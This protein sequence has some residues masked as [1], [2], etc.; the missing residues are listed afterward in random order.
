[1][2]PHPDPP[3]SD[4]ALRLALTEPRR[5]TEFTAWQAHIP[6][7]FVVVRLV[8]PRRLVELGTAGG[9]AY[10]AFCQSV[11]VNG[12]DTECAAVDTWTGDPHSGELH[13]ELFENLRSHHDPLYGHFSRLVRSTFDD[14]RP[15]FADQT[16]DLLHIDGYHTYDAV[17]HD[18]ESWLPKMS[19][20]GVVLLH[21]VAVRDGDF[22]VWRL[23]E[24]IK[25]QYPSFAFLHGHGLGIVIVG[26]SATNEIRRFVDHANARDSVASLFEALG[27]R[28]VARTRLN[29]LRLAV[30]E[31]RAR[32]AEL[33]QAH[34]ELGF[35]L[36]RSVAER[37]VAEERLADLERRSVAERG[38]AE[39]R[40]GDLE[41]RHLADRSLT[42]EQL[43]ALERQV[44]TERLER[45]TE[46]AARV[47]AERHLAELHATRTLRYTRAA[48][49]AYARLRRVRAPTKNPALDLA[50]GS[51]AAA[52]PAHESIPEASHA[53][54]V[55]AGHFYSA[56]PSLDD[57]DHRHKEIFDRDPQD[58]GGIDLRLS[59]QV[60]FLERLAPSLQ[61]VPFSD[62]PTP[63]LRYHFQ[64][65][66]FDSSDGLFLHLIL[67]ELRPS[68][69][70]EVGSGYS[71]AC[72]L[73][74]IEHFLPATR[75]TF[76]DPNAVTLRSLLRPGERADIIESP[77]QHVAGDLFSELGA[78]DLL[79][80]DSTHVVKAGSDV[81]YLF[82]DVLPELAPGV[83]VQ[84]HDVFPGFEYPW[85][86]LRE[87]R[88]WS[89]DYLL[90]AFLQYNLEFQILLWPRL[91]AEVVPDVYERFVRSDG[92][93]G[94]SIYIRR[95]HRAETDH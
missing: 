80:I 37:D 27:E 82:F 36:E 1:M 43:Q 29:Q 63:S 86:W 30:D 2:T 88:V 11:E 49:S 8:S 35:A 23:W 10:C 90:R 59:E 20:R 52:D 13:A 28:L 15:H 92:H 38:I 32:T 87:G 5:V 25:D 53:E 39:E 3:L 74:T 26:A 56:I 61:S 42:D 4:D 84:I 65:S 95:M 94:G 44:E 75:T 47:G 89:E 45:L 48:R 91:L 50:D 18:F 57:L 16:I 31:N 33:E 64:N 66:M 93:V 24:E 73:D 51:T 60:A 21:D 77:V 19:D 17:K 83:V 72:M 62:A 67:R 81:N 14:A 12:L 34:V 58:V 69:I 46:H 85:S 70:I 41:R 6:F 54:F 40:L 7:A 55:P 22:G 78:G 68:R 79:F 71:S 9:D 76:I